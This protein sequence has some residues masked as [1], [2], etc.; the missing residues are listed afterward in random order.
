MCQIIRED[1]KIHLSQLSPSLVS[2]P[3]LYSYIF[4]IFLQNHLLSQKLLAIEFINELFKHVLTNTVARSC[5]EGDVS[6]RMPVS[7]SFR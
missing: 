1:R 3:A 7:D 6:I 4:T 2:S 5:T